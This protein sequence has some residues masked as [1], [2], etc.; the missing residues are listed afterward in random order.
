[1]D[2]CSSL[3]GNIPSATKEIPRVVWTPLRHGLQ[4]MNS[5]HVPPDSFLLSSQQDAGLSSGLFSSIFFMFVV[6]CIVILG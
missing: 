2:I 5:V 4:R 1:M 6:P 3:E